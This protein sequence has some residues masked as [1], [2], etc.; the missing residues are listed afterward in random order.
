VALFVAL[1]SMTLTWLAVGPSRAGSVAAWA[2][3]VLTAAQIAV[4][5]WALA[6][7]LRLLTIRRLAGSA[8]AL[9]VSFVTAYLVLDRIALGIL[10]AHPTFDIARETYEAFRAGALVAGTR[11]F[12]TLVLAILAGWF[13]LTVVLKTL[14]LLPVSP[15]AEH[16]L[17]RAAI[18]GLLAVGTAS[19]LRACVLGDA[20]SAQEVAGAIPWDPVVQAP[21]Y[22]GSGA[23]AG[24]RMAALL[25]EERIFELLRARRG[26]ILAA[27]VRARSRPDI[28]ILHIESL[29]SDML[30]ADVTPS[31][32]AL[33]KESLVPRHHLTTGTN[34]GTGVFGILDGLTSP[35]YPLA[36][37]DHFQPLPLQLLKALGY[38]IS[39]YFANNF[40]QYDGLYDL[41]FAGL[42]DFTYAPPGRAPVYA[43][44]GEMVDSYLASVHT[45]PGDVPRFDYI[46]LDSTHY[47]YSYPPAFE[48]FTPAMTLDLGIRDGVVAREGISEELKPRAA[49]VK[50][51]YQNSI[52]YADSLVQ[53][54][55]DRLRQTGRL[56]HTIVVVTGDHGEEFW[57]RGVFGHGYGDLS[58]EQ[59]EVPL[60][61]RIPGGASTRYRYSSHAD[62]FPT[63][64]DAIGLATEGGAFMNGKSLLTYDAALD[65]AVAGFGVTGEQIDHRFVVRGDGLAVHWYDAPPF[66]VTEVT[67][68][69]D[70]P[71]PAPPQARVDDLLFHA[72]GAKGLR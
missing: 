2:L 69:D 57:E 43:A 51:R 25:G 71:L 20:M 26:A 50:N 17:R 4:F 37:R 11:G 62:I 7:L 32:V 14:A 63:L 38:R 29:R 30:R 27:P 40:R 1:S 8:Y 5:T 13:L 47:D 61:I 44:D 64:F 36:R 21:R 3:L 53:K 52:L 12:V 56:E 60:L 15:R 68:D 34:T 46:V 54:I 39:V 9:A 16:L 48:R 59:C 66:E 35:F 6:T 23:N 31:M 19:S 70:S 41:F 67:A 24:D 28:L 18:P 55:L 42:S 49:F 65:F 10:H 22:L 72:I 33:A 45:A 58:T